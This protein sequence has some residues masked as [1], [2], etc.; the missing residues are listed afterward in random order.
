MASKWGKFEESCVKY[1]NETYSACAS[2]SREGGSNSKQPDIVATT[3]TGD[4]FIIEVKSKSAQ[5]FQFTLLPVEDSR[6]FLYT[7]TLK[8]NPACRRIK[9]YM[10]KTTQQRQQKKN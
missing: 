10:E 9:A 2:F 8:E 6:T 3:V 1:L 5:G 7:A 4:Q